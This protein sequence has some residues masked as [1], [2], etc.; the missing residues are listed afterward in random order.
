MPQIPGI[1]TLRQIF[2]GS[3]K[4]QLDL[5]DKYKS[6]INDNSPEEAIKIL[7][8]I[9]R[10]IN[11]EMFV[12]AFTGIAIVAIVILFAVL[13]AY[14]QLFNK[15]IVPL[16]TETALEYLDSLKLKPNY[17]LNY[18]GSQIAI[19]K[20]DKTIGFLENSNN[21]DFLTIDNK[22]GDNSKWKAKINSSDSVFEVIQLIKS[23]GSII[24]KKYPAYEINKS[25][26]FNNLNNFHFKIKEGKIEKDT[27]YEYK[28][29]FGEGKKPNIS[30]TENYYEYTNTPN[31]E[32]RINDS[33]PIYLEKD[34]WH[35][36]YIVFFGI[37]KFAEDKRIYKVRSQ[38]FCLVIKDEN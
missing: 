14:Q 10:G 36:T 26:P 27:I 2:T 20:D 18:S 19:S 17:K 25:Y 38:A 37:G 6:L 3:G 22:N 15:E 8:T 16:T 21:K 28:I 30:W 35:N 24:P 33:P 4:N 11:I 23:S 7:R 1:E 12:R 34:N 5:I 32:G 9:L 13:Y 29:L 31:G